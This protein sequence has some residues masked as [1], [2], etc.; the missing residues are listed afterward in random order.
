MLDPS[1][2]FYPYDDLAAFQQKARFY[3]MPPLEDGGEYASWTAWQEAY[4]RFKAA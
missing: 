4:Q 2:K 1:L 3:P